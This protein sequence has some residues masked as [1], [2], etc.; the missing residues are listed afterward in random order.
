MQILPV[1]ASAD[2]DGKQGICI[3]PSE[4]RKLCCFSEITRRD[5]SIAGGKY[6]Q[7]EAFFLWVLFVSFFC[8]F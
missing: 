7:A 5:D 3:L 6:K 1:L 4:I 8:K 2:N